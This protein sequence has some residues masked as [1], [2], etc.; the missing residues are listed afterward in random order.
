MSGR[1]EEMHQGR[2]DADHDTSDQSDQQ[3]GLDDD[4]G[5]LP[6]GWDVAVDHEGRTY[7]IDHNTRTTTWDH[8]MGS[9]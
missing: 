2:G 7:Y 4:D 6:D 5:S 9:D 3:S 8:P 1:Q